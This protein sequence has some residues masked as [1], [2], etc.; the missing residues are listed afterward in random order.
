VVVGSVG[1]A[2]GFVLATLLVRWV[3]LAL[4]RRR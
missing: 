4:G 2:V 1:V 3:G